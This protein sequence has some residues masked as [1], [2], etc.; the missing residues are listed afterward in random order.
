MV[1]FFFPIASLFKTASFLKL[2]LI[3]GVNDPAAERRCLMVGKRMTCSLQEPSDTLAS[4]SSKEV[5]QELT[6]GKKVNECSDEMNVF[7]L[8][9]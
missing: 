4:A 9:P 7:V 2:L 3:L 1:N 6:F 8:W 5:C